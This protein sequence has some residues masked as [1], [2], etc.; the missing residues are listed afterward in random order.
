MK[1]P[2]IQTNPVFLLKSLDG[3]GVTVKKGRSK[4]K[5]NGPVGVFLNNNPNQLSTFYLASNYRPT[6]YQTW[7]IMHVFLFSI[8]LARL[9]PFDPSHSPFLK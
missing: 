2:E 5:I 6:Y 8:S 4:L 1:T 9:I 3:V 7:S